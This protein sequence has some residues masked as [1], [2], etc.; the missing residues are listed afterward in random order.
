M[1][2]EPN[3]QPVT[4]EG[5]RLNAVIALDVI[6]SAVKVVLSFSAGRRARCSRVKSFG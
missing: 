5:F 3:L 2:H 4:V 1:N 6:P